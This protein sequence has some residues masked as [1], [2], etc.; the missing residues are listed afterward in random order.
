VTLTADTLSDGASARRGSATPTR[1]PTGDNRP[2]EFWSTSAIREALENDNL[3]V[4][5][6]IATAIKRDPFGRTARQVE[7]VLV[8]A[9]PYGVTKVLTEVLQRTRDR[10]EAN[11]CAEVAREVRA[12][13]NA[14]GLGKS[15]F[16]SR[17]GVTDAEFGTYLDGRISPAASLMLRMRRLSERFAKM[18]TP[19]PHR[20]D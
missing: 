3:N 2:V 7:E 9:Q 20:P 18:R 10:L 14:S 6:Q 1:R 19:P 12:L 4:W 16:A 8:A 17:I 11:E 5:Q 13:H 15:E